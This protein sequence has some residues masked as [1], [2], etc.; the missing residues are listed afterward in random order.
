MQHK[1]AYISNMTVSRS[2]CVEGEGWTDTT[3]NEFHW[4]RVSLDMEHLD[5]TNTAHVLDRA[6]DEIE[7]CLRSAYCWGDR[8]S[9]P[10][11][12]DRDVTV[13][14]DSFEKSEHDTINVYVQASLNNDDD[15]SDD[16]AILD[17]HFSLERTFNVT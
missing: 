4:D 13:H 12:P 6:L 15:D 9:P 11:F 14:E 8:S 17:I 3:H 5:G 2:E 16:G 7:V 1:N 10:L